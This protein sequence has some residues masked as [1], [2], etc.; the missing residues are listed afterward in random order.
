MCPN[1]TTYNFA[2]APKSHVKLKKNMH[3]WKKTMRHSLLCS[4][5]E[6]SFS[7]FGMKKKIFKLILWP[8]QCR[9][10]D[11]IYKQWNHPL[12]NFITQQFV[13]TRKKSAYRR[14]V[15][16]SK[17]THA[18]TYVLLRERTLHSLSQSKAPIFNYES[19]SLAQHYDLMAAGRPRSHD[20]LRG[21]N[22]KHISR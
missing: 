21:T 13:E 14:T 1:I 11:A 9:L 5:K 6:N 7:Q 17:H 19:A 8:P 20:W 15:G 22:N 3:D 4:H 16:A 18:N 10:S 2:Y 12:K